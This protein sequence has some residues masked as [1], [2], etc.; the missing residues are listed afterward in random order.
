M[1]GSRYL[2]IIAAQL[3]DKVITVEEINDFP[4][5]IRDRIIIISGI[6]NSQ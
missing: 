6:N 2:N 4:E 5:D 3:A 1:S